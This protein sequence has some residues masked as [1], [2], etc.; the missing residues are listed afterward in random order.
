MCAQAG[1]SHRLHFNRRHWAISYA[2]RGFPVVGAPLAVTVTDTAAESR[3][4]TIV[5]N[6]SSL[7]GLTF[8]VI[9]AARLTWS[10]PTGIHHYAI[11]ISSIGTAHALA[12]KPEIGSSKMDL[13][14]GQGAVR[15][16]RS[17]GSQYRESPKPTGDTSK[18]YE[19]IVD[20]ATGVLLHYAAVT[21]DGIAAAS[22]V[23]WIDDDTPITDTVLRTAVPL[24]TTVMVSRQA[25]TW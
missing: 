23:H 3:P 14:S 8:I 9:V 18:V 11:A 7:P 1:E 25:S 21:N 13:C 22:D 17:A 5:P 12:G 15:Q 10:D 2:T 4:P 19:G 24:G 16:S 6:T 20:R